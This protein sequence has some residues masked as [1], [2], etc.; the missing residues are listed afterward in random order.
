VHVR[1]GAQECARGRKCCLKDSPQ[2]S[3]AGSALRVSRTGPKGCILTL[4]GEATLTLIRQGK[5]AELTADRISVNLVTGQVEGQIG[6]PPQNPP[7]PP[8]TPCTSQPVAP[9]AM[10]VPTC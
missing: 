9:T 6:H 10:P 7:V 8:V 2:D 5:K 3:L 4:E 1:S